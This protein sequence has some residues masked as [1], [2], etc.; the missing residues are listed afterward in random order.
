MFVYMTQSVVQPLVQ[1]VWQPIVSFKRGIRARSHR[2]EHDCI[3]TSKFW[4][5]SENNWVQF[6][7]VAAMWKDLKTNYNDVKYAIILLGAAF[8]GVKRP[9]KIIPHR[10]RLYTFFKWTWFVTR[11]A[12]TNFWSLLGIKS[13]QN[14]WFLLS[15]TSLTCE[16]QTK[17]EDSLLLT[18][19]R[20]N[21][22]PVCRQRLLHND[23]EM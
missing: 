7:P 20:H 2:A 10:K 9:I 8:C 11:F 3:G 23:R 18:R 22:Q 12:C 16:T 17:H 21:E 5:Y 19:S 6:N 15:R 14:T 4:T 1:P 13:M